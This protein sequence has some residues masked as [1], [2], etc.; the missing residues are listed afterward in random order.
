[1]RFFRGPDLGTT[2][3]IAATKSF[4]DSTFPKKRNQYYLRDPATVDTLQGI[5]TPS[6]R[7]DQ[8]DPT[9]SDEDTGETTVFV[10]RTKRTNRCVERPR[11]LSSHTRSA[12]FGITFGPRRP[13]SDLVESLRRLE[14]QGNKRR[15]PLVSISTT[16]VETDRSYSLLVTLSLKE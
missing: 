15:K 13:L 10:T 14:V 1:M 6:L 11:C 8:T 4:D 3:G 7:P 16:L 5:R 12:P 9:G 2:V